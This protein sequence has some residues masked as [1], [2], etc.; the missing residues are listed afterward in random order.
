MA[1][2]TYEEDVFD[3]KAPK[4]LFL[5]TGNGM[6]KFG[7]GYPEL[8]MGAGI[9][10]EFKDRFPT[11]PSHMAEKIYDMAESQ[12]VLSPGAAGL[13]GPWEY[14]LMIYDLQNSGDFFTAGYEYPKTWLVGAFQ[15]K[16]NWKD[17][18][19]LELIRTS[20]EA[21]TDWALKNPDW[22]I[23]SAMPGCGNGGLTPDEV[24]GV[25]K[26]LGMPDN[27]KFFLK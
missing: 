14:N 15:S 19:S 5:F 16:L 21:L 2:L 25:L 8:V 7:S 13:R 9:A 17:K 12:I 3:T 6:I 18:S 1:T 27:V 20:A 11:L 24:I 22:E 26:D 10:K 4:V 23:R